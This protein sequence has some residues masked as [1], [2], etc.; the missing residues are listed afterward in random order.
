VKSEPGKGTLFKLYFPAQKKAAGAKEETPEEIRGGSERILM[1]D[2]DE[3]IVKLN[4]QRLTRLGYRVKSTQEPLKAL[5]WF[6][7]APDGFDV[8]ITDMTMPKMTGDK[9]TKEI[10]SIR[11][12]LPVILCTGYSE[13]VPAKDAEALGAAKYLEKPMEL[14]HL[15]SAIREVLKAHH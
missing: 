11:P 14:R 12:Q 3:A 13:R 1:V 15:A 2:D 4:H 5:E 7:A 9:L 8:V 10:L 6:R